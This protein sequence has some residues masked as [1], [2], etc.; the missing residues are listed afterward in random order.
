MPKDF[1]ALFRHRKA[2]KGVELSHEEFY[3]YFRN[4][5]NDI[6][7]VNNEEAEQFCTSNDFN[8]DPVFEDLDSSITAAE[9]QKMYELLETGKGMWH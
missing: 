2:A 3:Y 5:A 9:V 7:I 1:W 8:K 6:N 4:M